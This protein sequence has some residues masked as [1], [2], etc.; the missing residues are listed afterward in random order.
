MK[1]EGVRLIVGAIIVSKISNLC[2]PPDP[3][4]L[5]TDGRHAIAKTAALC[6]IPHRAVKMLF[7]VAGIPALGL[8]CTP[9][10]LTPPQKK[11]SYK[12]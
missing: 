3:P 7:V 11:K 8:Y 1:S 6:T 5:Q 9:P 10:V 4:T 12:L 2:S